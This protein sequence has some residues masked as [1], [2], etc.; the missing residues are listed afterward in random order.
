MAE[1]EV[2]I[3]GYRRLSVVQTGQNSEVWEVSDGA[4]RYIMKLL[5]PEKTYDRAHRR[6]LFHEAEVAMKLDHPKIIRVYSYSKNK[7][8]PYILMEP[9]L[10]P[11]LKLRLV[12]RQFD[13]FIRPRL[14]T[15]V[16]QAAAAI[17][18]VHEK[19]WVHR[20]IKPDN[21]LVGAS[22]DTRLIDF[23]LAVR[24]SSALSR[25][26]GRRGKTAGT[27]S[28]MSPEQIRGLPLD[29]RADIYSFGITLYEL[30]ATKLPFVARSANDL[31]R[32]HIG[33]GVPPI[34]PARKVTVE[35]EGLIGR[36][37]AKKAT[38]RVPSLGEFM[39]ELRAIRLFED[40]ET[41]VENP[42]G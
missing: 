24:T 37:L 15:I 22:G 26:F 38:D 28:Y 39:A 11:N 32:K 40:E 9:F 25:R 34:D 19:R 4:R 2:I 33:W 16:E 17:D 1:D 12:R 3:D 14:R 18:F 5:L 6:M 13:D 31:F 21:L 42:Y 35:F 27:R 7:Q 30:A 36:M 20:D 8:N 29:R 41:P 10:S 23:A